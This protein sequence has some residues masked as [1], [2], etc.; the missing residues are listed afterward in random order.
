MYPREAVLH[1]E[2]DTMNIGVE[3]T[4]YFQ[5]NL[6][7]NRAPRDGREFSVRLP[8]V[9]DRWGDHAQWQLDE[10]QGQLDVYSCAI[11]YGVDRPLVDWAIP[12]TRFD[13][14]ASLAVMHDMDQTGPSPFDP[15]NTHWEPKIVTDP[16][17]VRIGQ[18]HFEQLSNIVK[19]LR[20]SRSEAARFCIALA[21]RWWSEPVYND[22]MATEYNKETQKY[23]DYFRPAMQQRVE[24][25]RAEWGADV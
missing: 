11:E 13:E 7:H 2:V 18:E 21:F 3:P 17:A 12:V 23:I 6:Q 10:G 8:E 19:L 9:L 15:I 25:A 5:E 22:N 24:H 4:Q 14:I 16:Q 1:T 20:C